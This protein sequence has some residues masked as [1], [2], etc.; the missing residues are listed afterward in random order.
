MNGDPLAAENTFHL[1]DTFVIDHCKYF[2]Q[3]YPII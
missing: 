1:L 3:P 2:L